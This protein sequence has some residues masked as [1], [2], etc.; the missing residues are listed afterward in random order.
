MKTFSKNKLN[1]LRE[2][3]GQSLIELSVAVGI[4]SIALIAILSLVMMGIVTQRRSY[5]YYTAINLARE[6][7]E[8]ARNVRDTNWLLIESGQKTSDLWD[9]NLY[10]GT[11]YSAVLRIDPT[12]LASKYNFEFMDPVDPNKTLIYKKDLPSGDIIFLDYNC[13]SNCQATIFKRLV[14]LR[15][16]CNGNTGVPG[17]H[18]A[19]LAAS[20]GEDECPEDST[21]FSDPNIK[22]NFICHN[23]WT[24]QVD[25]A[26]KIGVRVIVEMAWQEG[27]QTKKLELI[28]DIYNWR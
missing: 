25:L 19:F 3:R 23:N 1:F 21:V 9:D 16:I 27:G 8:V 24:C 13:L 14:Y 20:G 12:S 18:E 5:N 28:D 26:P 2:Q 4:T 17:N 6:A 22:P 7:I 15:P 11:T 10:E